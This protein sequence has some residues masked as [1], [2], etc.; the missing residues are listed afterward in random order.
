MVT[1]TLLIGSVSSLIERFSSCSF[2]AVTTP[3]GSSS[4][5]IVALPMILDVISAVSLSV[6]VMV[7]TL[8]VCVT[9]DPSGAVPSVNATVSASSSIMS[10]VAVN[11]ITP[12]MLPSPADKVI[13]GGVVVPS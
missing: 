7:V 11:V 5:S 9:I 10:D 8:A 4:S 3:V 1:V 12:V 13:V 6:M 2:A